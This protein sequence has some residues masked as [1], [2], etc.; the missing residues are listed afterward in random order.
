MVPRTSG[1]NLLQIHLE[2]GSHFGDSISDIDEFGEPLGSHIWLIQDNAG[3]TSSMSWWGGIVGSNDDLDL[4]ED[5]SSSSLLSA[6]EVDGSGSLSIESHDLGEGLSDEELK[7]G[8][9]EVSEASSI[10][11]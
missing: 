3:N 4:G 6:H 5:L 7:A 8:V 1:T 9:D 10:L 2:E 11:V